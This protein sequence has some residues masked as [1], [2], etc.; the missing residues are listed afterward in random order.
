MPDEPKRVCWDSCVF[1]SYINE[2]ADRLPTIQAVFEDANPDGG[3]V[4]IITSFLSIV[5]VAYGLTEQQ[6]KALD[7]EVE[8]NIG[9]LW[10]PDSPVRL[11]EPYRNITNE[12]RRFI[13]E[14][15]L[16][17]WSLKAAD[18]VHLATAACMEAVEFHTY[19]DK[20]T[21]YDKIT[22]LSICE[23]YT[24]RPRLNL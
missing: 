14:A 21:K 18:A 5:E 8:E 11:V 20:L 13:R 1:I 16:K 15:M 6:G 24:D 3:S 17:G 12:A 22:G 9:K 2:D 4:E 19:D 10:L 7:P 23:P